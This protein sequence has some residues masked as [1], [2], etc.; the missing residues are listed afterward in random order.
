MLFLR[1]VLRRR[2]RYFGLQLLLLLFVFLLQ[3]LRLL[4]VFL[5]DLL[6]SRLVCFLLG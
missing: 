6:R 3:L 5:L 2:L 4:L 1:N